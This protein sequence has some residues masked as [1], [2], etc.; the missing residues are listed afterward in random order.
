M[1]RIAL[2]NLV[3]PKTFEKLLQ[4]LSSRSWPKGQLREDHSDY[5]DFNSR[6]MNQTQLKSRRNDRPIDNC[7]HDQKIGMLTLMPLAA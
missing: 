5:A 4:H 3:C 7:R 6:P 1:Q 2:S